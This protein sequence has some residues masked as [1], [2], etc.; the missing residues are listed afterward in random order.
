MT[1]AGHRLG[2]GRQCVAWEMAA[3]TRCPNMT[4]QAESIGCRWAVPVLLGL[5]GIA[6]MPDDAAGSCTSDQL[7]ML[8]NYD[9]GLLNAN[10]TAIDTTTNSPGR[11]EDF[12]LDVLGNWP[13][14]VTKTDGTTQLNHNREHNLA[15]EIADTSGNSDAIE[16]T[17]GS[18]W[19]NPVWDASGNMTDGPLP[20]VPTGTH[21]VKYDAWNR[22]VYA[23]LV[24]PNYIRKYYYDG[25]NRMVHSAWYNPTVQ[26][27][28]VE[29]HYY[30]HAWQRLQ[31]YSSSEQNSALTLAQTAGGAHV[32][33]L[34][35]I[36]SLITNGSYYYT[37]DANFNVTSAV[38][39]NGGNPAQRF[40]YD[41]YGQWHSY[42]VYDIGGQKAWYDNGQLTSYGR[43]LY[44]GYYADYIMK[45]YHVRNRAYNSALG[46]WM[47]RDPGV[48]GDFPMGRGGIRPVG[49]FAAW[50][51]YRFGMDLYGYALSRPLVIRDSRGLAPDPIWQGQITGCSGG[52]GQPDPE[53]DRRWMDEAW[54]RA[55]YHYDCAHGIR[56]HCQPAAGG[57]EHAY[58]YWL[59][60]HRKYLRQYESHRDGGEGQW[61]CDYYSN[62]VTGDCC[63]NDPWDAEHRCREAIVLSTAKYAL[64]FAVRAGESGAVSLVAGGVGT[65]L[66]VVPG[67][68][69]VAGISIGIGV[70]FM[71]DMF[72]ELH[73][74]YDVQDAG[75]RAADL[76]C[77]CKRPV[78]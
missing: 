56:A 30:N 77:N 39:A 5:A 27:W 67:G 45:Y 49:Q 74:M 72:Y 40:G 46:R 48:P 24:Q 29:D 2:T 10:K 34:R 61:L 44:A 68:Q 65:W 54:N 8:R 4:S 71:A 63:A 13:N 15:N 38:S 52:T 37:N 53:Y 21:V 55:M 26:K 47:Q 42:T 19:R 69:V 11:E 28:D 31:D 1:V 18:D 25:L 75:A 22:L 64:V 73:E 16:T 17:T 33:S 3:L 6:L 14:Y 70:I 12:T 41:P 78:K 20:T 23:D 36:D 62:R 50:G 7:Q 57:H 59:K 66:L 58:E 35:Y 51:G 76:F 9:R 32:W 43:V 60:E